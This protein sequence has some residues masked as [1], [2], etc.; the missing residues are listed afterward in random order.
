[1][2]IDQQCLTRNCNYNTS[3]AW[4]KD[5]IHPFS[6]FF[7]KYFREK[8]II[9]YVL[10]LT[11]IWY[12]GC[13]KFLDKGN[14][15]KVIVPYQNSYSIRLQVWRSY[16]LT[17]LLFLDQG[18]DWQIFKC[19]LCPACFCWTF[20][21]TLFILIHSRHASVEGFKFTMKIYRKPVYLTG[22]CRTLSI[23]SAYVST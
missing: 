12:R 4:Q 19:K 8:N 5:C 11:I 2:Y 14:K 6:Q 7:L 9:A 21:C 15:Y 17:I 10:E 16:N 13:I 3:V 23:F 1:M 18:C 22:L 20:S